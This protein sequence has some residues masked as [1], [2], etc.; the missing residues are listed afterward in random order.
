MQPS[1]NLAK[2]V[3]E[4]LHS[5]PY[6]SKDDGGGNKW[7]YKTSKAPVK[8]SHQQTN[9]QLFTGQMRSLS[10]YLFPSSLESEAEGRHNSGESVD[11]ADLFEDHIKL[12]QLLVSLESRIG[13]LFAV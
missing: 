2:P 5:R 1:F 8:S 10:E 11:I 13:C 3:P 4:C 12:L 7:S 9:I 6:W